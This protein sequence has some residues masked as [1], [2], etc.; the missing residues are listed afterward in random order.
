M[1]ALTFIVPGRLDTLTG[2]YGY[3][4]RIVAGLR[5]RGWLGT[6]HEIDDGFSIPHGAAREQ[7]ARVLA[8]IPDDAFVI[9]D[10]LAL[11]ALPDEVQPHAERLRLVGLVHHP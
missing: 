11:G 3:D 8:A 6:L 1:R 4:R 7:A 9:V 10:G 2:G 5:E